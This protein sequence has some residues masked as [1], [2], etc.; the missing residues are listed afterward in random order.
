M[1]NAGREVR[2]TPQQIQRQRRKS[3][4]LPVNAKSV[5][6]AGKG[7]RLPMGRWGNPFALKTF[8]RETVLW[9]FA[10]YASQRLAV[11][12]DWLAQ[13]R[14]KDLTC[15]CPPGQACHADILLRLANAS[16]R[17]GDIGVAT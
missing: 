1:G 17:D 4:S 8:D 13:L 5:T 12:P 9:L 16:L 14:G 7:A 10:I 2:S 11:E 15:W 3:C 6:R